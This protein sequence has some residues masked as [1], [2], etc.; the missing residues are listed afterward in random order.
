LP[1][2]ILYETEA[3]FVVVQG[4]DVIV[5]ERAEKGR[6]RDE[7][8]RRVAEGVKRKGIARLKVSS[9]PAKEKM[10]EFGI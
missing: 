6:E 4:D 9:M 8:L 5:S 7:K 1:E 10:E 2:P 3:G